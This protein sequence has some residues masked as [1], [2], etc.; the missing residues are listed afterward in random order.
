MFSSEHVQDK[1]IARDEELSDSEDEGDGRRNESN[2][3]DNNRPSEDEN[4]KNTAVSK[5]MGVTGGSIQSPLPPEPS[6]I[7][8]GPLQPPQAEEAAENVEGKSEL[9]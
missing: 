2:A 5:T 4:N 1:L 8:P 7:T 9:N 6:P 3:Q